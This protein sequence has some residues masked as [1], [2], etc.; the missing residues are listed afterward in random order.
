M[1]SIIVPSPSPGEATQGAAQNTRAE[2]RETPVIR[3][4]NEPCGA[5]ES[6]RIPHASSPML[7]RLAGA[8]G[9]NAADAEPFRFA[10]PKAAVYRNAIDGK[11][12]AKVQLLFASED[13]GSRTTVSI[14]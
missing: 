2:R 11:K 6:R 5:P 7:R 9:S 10:P 14:N 4:Q 3:Q 8:P 1:E 13:V 12:T